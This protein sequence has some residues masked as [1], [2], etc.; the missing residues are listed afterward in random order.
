MVVSPKDEIWVEANFKESQ[1]G[2]I[3]AGHRVEVKSDLYQGKVIHHGVVIGLGAGTGSVFSLLPPENA[4]GNW[5]KV[6]QRVPVKIMLDS[7]DLEKYPL[8]LGLS[9]HV[10]VFVEESKKEILPQKEVLYQTDVLNSDLED[11]DL[12]IQKTIDLN[13]NSN[14]YQFRAEKS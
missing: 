1:L 11:I 2:R 8:L 13:L 14:N 7:K 5:I 4:T 6:V 3:G 9:C 10:K 12:E